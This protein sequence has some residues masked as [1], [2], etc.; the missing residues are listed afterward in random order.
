MTQW[1]R[2]TVLENAPVPSTFKS[3]SCDLCSVALP[4][5]EFFQKCFSLAEHAT[6]LPPKIQK[7]FLKKSI[8]W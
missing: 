4:V 1:L 3:D 7:H 6:A 2:T 5:D 8:N